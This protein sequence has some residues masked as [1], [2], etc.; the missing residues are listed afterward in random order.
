[1]AIN[2]LERERTQTNT[3]C[4]EAADIAMVLLFILMVE[5]KCFNL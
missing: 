2:I 5:R 3:I 4:C 1:M